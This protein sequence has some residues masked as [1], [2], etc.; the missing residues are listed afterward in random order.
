MK[1]RSLDRLRRA[2]RKN[3]AVLKAQGT[4]LGRE[5]RALVSS[6]KKAFAHCAMKEDLG[7]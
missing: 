7:H 6:W 3:T 1:A 5:L 4:L 2:Q